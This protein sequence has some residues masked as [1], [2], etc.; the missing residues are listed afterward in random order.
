MRYFDNFE[1][2]IFINDNPQTI[3]VDSEDFITT[4]SG[5]LTI[6][7]G[8]EDTLILPEGTVQNTNKDDAYYDYYE[9]EG[10]T[11]AVSEVLSD[12]LLIG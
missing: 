1:F 3:I 8:P 11:I 9:F 10:I 2:Y 12:N 6:G 4:S 7:G 5:L